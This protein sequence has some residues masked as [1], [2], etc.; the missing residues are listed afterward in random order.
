MRV[1]RVSGAPGASVVGLQ[2]RADGGAVAAVLGRN[3]QPVATALWHLDADQVT[4]VWHAA[5]GE[6]YPTQWPYPVFAPDLSQ[7]VTVGQEGPLLR[8]FLALRTE[9]EPD[10]VRFAPGDPRYQ[11]GAMTF[12]PNG[13]ELVALASNGHPAYPDDWQI[14]TAL[15]ALTWD[16]ADPRSNPRSSGR[17]GVYAAHT[18][19]MLPGE[20]LRHPK[21]LAI[22]PGGAALAIGFNG[23]LDVRDWPGLARTGTWSDPREDLGPAVRKLAFTAAGDALLAV[24]NS[25]LLVA[26]VSATGLAPRYHIPGEGVATVQDAALSPDGRLLVTACGAAG[27]TVYDAGT[28]SELQTFRGLVGDAWAVA[29]APDGLTCAVGG[30]NGQVAIWDVDG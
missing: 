8:P 16:T 4:S 25:G 1:Q 13:R 30:E 19:T 3:R 20:T 9:A 24:S 12:A 27:I 6:T 11:V 21:A 28:G 5:R 17:R 15:A 29:F 7:S 2:Y 10:G 23:R 22:A 14:P 26:D 18:V